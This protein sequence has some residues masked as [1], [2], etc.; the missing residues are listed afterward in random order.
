MTTKT[1]TPGYFMNNGHTNPTTTIRKSFIKG[2][3]WNPSQYDDPEYEKKLNAVY[4]ERDEGNA[5]GDD[6]RNSRQGSL[7]MATDAPFS[8]R[9]G[10]G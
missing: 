9:G 7:R 8:R 1:N 5:E 4:L 2:Q 10:P 6:T 3:V